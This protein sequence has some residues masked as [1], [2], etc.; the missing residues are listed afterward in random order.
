MSSDSYS[1]ARRVAELALEKQAEDVVL[2]DLRELSSACDYFVLATGQREQQVRAITEHIELEMKQEEDRPWHV[3]GRTHRRWVL[4]DFVDVVAHV[5]HKES[6][7]FYLLEK[8]W[9]DAPREDIAPQV[10]S[11]S[12]EEES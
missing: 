10:S 2:L 5:F 1:L 8:L 4:L 11:T 12:F 7:E 3:E 9:S 6:R